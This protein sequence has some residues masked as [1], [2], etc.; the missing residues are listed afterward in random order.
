MK[1]KRQRDGPRAYSA[2]SDVRQLVRPPPAPSLYPS[3][4]PS[5]DPPAFQLPQG[6]PFVQPRRIEEKIL[7]RSAPTRLR[8]IPSSAES[9]DVESTD[10]P[11]I[12]NLNSSRNTT[13]TGSPTIYA[14]L[15]HRGHGERFTPGRQSDIGNKINPLGFTRKS[16]QSSPHGSPDSPDNPPRGRRLRS[17]SSSRQKVEFGLP[18]AGTQS[19]RGLQPEKGSI[20]K[21]DSSTPMETGQ[22]SELQ[23][24]M[25]SGS[26][27]DIEDKRKDETNNEESL[28]FL[29]NLDL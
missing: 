18:K 1:P 15:Q 28:D 10:R 23:F 11:E 8:R 26:K 7:S 17:E 12:R 2:P 20:L 25:D 19:G 27:K 9:M 6:S 4:S 29:S 16:P 22:F 3:P 21:H 13:P 24:Q 14:I 5:F